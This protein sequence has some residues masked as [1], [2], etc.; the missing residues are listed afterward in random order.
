MVMME[1]GLA[2]EFAKKE[3]MMLKNMPEFLLAERMVTKESM[4]GPGQE[5]TRLISIGMVT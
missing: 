2:K 1:R 4:F 5:E 3:R